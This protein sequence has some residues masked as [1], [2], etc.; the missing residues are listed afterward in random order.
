MTQH[1]RDT[2]QAAPA[3]AAPPPCASFTPSAPRSPACG[4]CPHPFDSHAPEP[5]EVLRI[6]GVIIA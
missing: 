5:R 4:N 1:A 2:S 6:R 3:T